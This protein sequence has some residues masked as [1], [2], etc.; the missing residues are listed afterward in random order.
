MLALLS[1]LPHPFPS[2]FLFQF[3][4]YFPVDSLSP[5]FSS[6]SSSTP[7]SY[8][9]LLFPF[10]PSSFLP[11]PFA[12]PVFFHSSS[13]SL[14]SPVLYPFPSL[15]LSF[16]D[17]GMVMLPVLRCLDVLVFY[18]RQHICYSAYMLWQFRLSV[19]LSV[20][21]SVTWVDLDQSKTVEARITQFSPYSSPFP[22]VFRG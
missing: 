18:A 22:L 21:L 15:F 9:F 10:P 14:P 16:S 13:H 4:S 19:R 7:F 12:P 11:H 20:C 5:A 3:L 8:P 17:D 2:F 6:L 1:F